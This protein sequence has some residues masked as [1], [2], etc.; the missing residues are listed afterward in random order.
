MMQRTLLLL[1]ALLGG[2]AIAGVFG[3][4]PVAAT[5]CIPEAFQ[6]EFQ[7]EQADRIV[8]GRVVGQQRQAEYT[9]VTFA[10]QAW[11]KD[12]LSFATIEIRTPYLIAGALEFADGEE[13]IVTL[14]DVEA[15]RGIFEAAICLSAKH[16]TSLQAEITALV[17][18]EPVQP[19]QPPA[20]TPS[21]LQALLATLLPIVAAAAGV[22]GFG[23]AVFVGRNA[24][25]P[26]N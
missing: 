8:V 5:T 15:N 13:T 24:S 20:P 10:V 25:Q 16:P 17:G 11:L 14:Q 12:A 19:V 21:P 9:A 18:E 6:L 7:V 4:P 23:V 26:V 2:L 3:V 1:L 22:A